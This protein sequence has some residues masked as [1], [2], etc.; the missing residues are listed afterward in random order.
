MKNVRKEPTLNHAPNSK[1]VHY[2]CIP[3]AELR[4]RQMSRHIQI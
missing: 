2:L 1:N 4:K 3:T